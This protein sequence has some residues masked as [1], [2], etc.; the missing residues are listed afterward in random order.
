M[1]VIEVKGLSVALAGRPILADIDLSVPAGAILSVLGTSGCGKTT[2]LRAIAGFLPR[3]AAHIRPPVDRI[4]MVFQDPRLLPWLSV[5][6]NIGFALEADGVPRRQ[7]AA[8]IEPLLELVGL[9]QCRGLRPAA[10]SGGMAQRV[11]LVRA[12]VSRPEVLLLDE[13]FAALDPQRRERLQGELQSLVAD[14]RCAAILVTHDVMEAL[15]LGDEVMILGQ[16]QVLHSLH[17]P[18][19]RPRGED[20][21][22]S[23]ATLQLQ[24]QVREVLRQ[25][26]DSGCK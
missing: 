15:V 2:L 5:W 20:F 17:V 10:L 16:G 13:P 9:S 23:A 21:R 11:A 8:R 26:G 4:R 18:A 14:T 25:S 3:S 19:A 24:V 6:D 12:L 7:W 22:L 1:A